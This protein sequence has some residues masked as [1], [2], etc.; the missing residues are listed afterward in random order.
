MLQDNQILKDSEKT[1]EES[2][3]NTQ[4]VKDVD[5]GGS[6]E[7]ENDSSKPLEILPKP[8]KPQDT[9]SIEET[10]KVQTNDTVLEKEPETTEKQQQANDIQKEILSE[11]KK[12]NEAT[13]DFNT[14]V[15]ERNEK[16]D[17]KEAEEQE[18][19]DAE[20]EEVSDS[21]SSLLSALTDLSAKFD[22]YT[23]QNEEILAYMEN[24]E[25]N[26][27]YGLAFDAVLTGFLSLL[28]GIFFGRIAFR[29]L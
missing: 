16:Q 26:T 20:K 27:S 8:D 4:G 5:S 10:D 28:A 14:Y 9:V 7:Q 13:A 24:I 15:E 1:E 18:S 23:V 11:L 19:A 2:K 12:L 25:F 21:Y 6:T 29:K 17:E 22:T 3:D